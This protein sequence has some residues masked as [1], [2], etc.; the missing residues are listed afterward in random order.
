MKRLEMRNGDVVAPDNL[1]LRCSR[2]HGGT[3]EAPGGALTQYIDK[4]GDPESVVRCAECGKKHSIDS[5]ESA[6]G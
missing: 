1:K 5:L 2:C 4:A 3:D 6:N